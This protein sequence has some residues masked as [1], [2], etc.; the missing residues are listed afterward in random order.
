MYGVRVYRQYASVVQKLLCYQVQIY[1]RVFKLDCNDILRLAR[2]C[3]ISVI[4]L[5]ILFL[6]ITCI[7]QKEMNNVNIVAD[8]DFFKRH[9]HFYF[10]QQLLMSCTRIKGC[11]IF[12]FRH[13]RILYVQILWIFLSKISQ[14]HSTHTRL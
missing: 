1:V 4:S 6:Q 8:D 10:E 9:T 13:F 2:S 14:M 3:T 5:L 7:D 12:Y 11:T